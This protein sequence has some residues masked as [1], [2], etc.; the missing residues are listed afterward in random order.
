MLNGLWLGF[1]LVAGLAALARWLVGGDPTVFYDV[2]Q[3]FN[4]GGADGGSPSCTACRDSSPA[5][6][7]STT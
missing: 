3:H 2:L 5:A 1:F 6:S 7:A 4:T